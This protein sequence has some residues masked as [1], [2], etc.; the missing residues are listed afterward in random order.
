M[1][2]GRKVRKG[3]FSLDR[4][5]MWGVCGWGCVGEWGN[6]FVRKKWDTTRSVRWN[7]DAQREEGKKG[8]L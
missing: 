4:V 5:C 7:Q 6:S 1:H 2:R 3:D 8:G